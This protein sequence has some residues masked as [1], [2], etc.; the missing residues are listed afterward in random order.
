[1][2]RHFPILIRKKSDKKGKKFK[3]MHRWIMMFK[4]GLSGTHDSVRYL[5]TYIH[6][7]MNTLTSLIAQNERRFLRELDEMNG[8]KASKPR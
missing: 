2:G 7:I 4:V 1:M 5:H 6:T 3:Q 8:R